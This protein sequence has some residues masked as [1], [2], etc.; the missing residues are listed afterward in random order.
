MMPEGAMRVKGTIMRWGRVVIAFAL[1]LPLMGLVIFERNDSVGAA[2][3]NITI[4]N[5]TFV[6]P[7]GVDGN[8]TITAGTSVTW[9]NMDPFAH[10]ATSDAVQPLFD[11]GAIA[12]GATTTPITFADVGIFPYHCQIHPFIPTMHGTITVISPAADPL[13][14]AKPSVAPLGNPAPLP[15]AHP[16]AVPSGNAPGPL[17]SQR[18]FV[19]PSSASSAPNASAPAPAPAPLP[20]GRR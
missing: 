20:T 8:F 17:P 15:A 5:F 4:Q 3:I 13:P 14:I 10:T 12:G 16:T 11:T 6:G 7:D 2:N 9:T 1:A 18:S 19:H